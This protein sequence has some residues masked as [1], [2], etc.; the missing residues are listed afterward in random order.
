MVLGALLTDGTARPALASDPELGGGANK[1]KGSFEFLHGDG[2]FVVGF[3]SDIDA[4]VAWQTA[5]TY[6]FLPGLHPTNFPTAFSNYNHIGVGMPTGVTGIISM[7]GGFSSAVPTTHA[8]VPYDRVNRLVLDTGST[9]MT[10]QLDTRDN[11]PFAPF[12]MKLEFFDE[13]YQRIIFEY[14]LGN[15]TYDLLQVA[16]CR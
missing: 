14:T 8:V 2:N 5:N 16:P 10:N 3:T 12:E 9:A 1:I 4:L 13:F 11:R 6:V 7:V 15:S